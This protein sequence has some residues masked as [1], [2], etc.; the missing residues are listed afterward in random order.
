MTPLA[1]EIFFGIT[2]DTYTLKR[3]DDW[4]IGEKR[5]ENVIKQII[6]YL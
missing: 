1:L 3:S 6:N 4:N 5:L 2:I